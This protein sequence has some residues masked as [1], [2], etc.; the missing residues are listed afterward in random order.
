VKYDKL[1]NISFQ[2]ECE[3]GCMRVCLSTSLYGWISALPHT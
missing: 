1:T 3:R 2:C